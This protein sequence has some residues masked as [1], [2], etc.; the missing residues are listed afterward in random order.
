M[1]KKTLGIVGHGR[2][3]ILVEKIVKKEFPEV[4][5]KIFEKN[6]NFQK[7]KLCNVIIIAVPISNFEEAILEI[8]DFIKPKTLV[9]DVCSVKIHPIEI[10][11][12]H[13]LKNVEIIATHPMF[14]P[15]SAKNGLSGLKIVIC[16]VRCKTRRFNN[17]KRTLKNIGLQITEM[18]PKEH[19][20][21]IAKSQ[22]FTHIV[23]RIGENLNIKQTNIDTESFR[24]LLEI[25]NVI[26][27]DS[28][29]L[30]IDM[31]KFNPFA[32]DIRRKIKTELDNL[33][34]QI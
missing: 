32:K 23:G 14:G 26:T 29:N 15:D 22:L 6:S 2:F 9:L 16:K 10:M 8:K 13:L 11:K 24:K 34:R 19:D 28:F 20:E 5:I 33:E 18:T 25:Q 21:L 4:E 17:I 3:G 12:K 31:N 1:N 7:I 30:F 27:N